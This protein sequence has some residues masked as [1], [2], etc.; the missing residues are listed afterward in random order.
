MILREAHFNDVT[1]IAQIHIDTWRTTYRGI[2][3]EDYLAQLSYK[4]R[5]QGWQQILSQAAVQGQFT[6]VVENQA[7]QVIGF[8]NGGPERKGNPLYKGELNAI[9][10]LDSYQQQGIGRQLVRMVVKR[11]AQVDI[12]SMLVWVL[13][14]NPACKFYQALGG[15]KVDEQLIERG[16]S[17]LKEVAYGWTDTNVLIRNSN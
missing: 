12:H 11:L 15:Q 13:A 1:R 6:Y 3:P 10:I 4:K 5:E 7:G 8:A 14:D 9:Y 17:Q 16:N 2:I